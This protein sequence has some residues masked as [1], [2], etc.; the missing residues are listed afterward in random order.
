MNQAPTESV[1]IMDILRS[2]GYRPEEDN[3]TT[4]GMPEAPAAEEEKTFQIPE[5]LLSQLQPPE[6]DRVRNMP[7]E[8]FSEPEGN[9]EKQDP[10]SRYADTLGKVEV[11]NDELE[12]YTRSLLFDERF[13]IPVRFFLG[14][15]PFE[16]VCRSL[17]VSERETMALAVSRIAA[18]YPIPSLPTAAVVADYYLKLALSVQVVSVNGKSF[19]AYDARPEAGQLPEDSPKIDEMVRLG[20][21]AF[22]DMHQ[23]K[24][25]TLIKAL[26]IF[27]V[28]QQILEDAYYN[29]DFRRPADAS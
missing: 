25:K 6:K 17:Y 11:T 7:G 2:N 13:E 20:R 23:A 14:D 15:E 28:K 1:D 21:L 24:L 26:H 16:V 19:D 18:N 3:A 4:E 29:R 22:Q 8:L 12:K 10:W 5:H 9:P 27:E